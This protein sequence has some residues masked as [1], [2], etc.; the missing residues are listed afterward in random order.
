MTPLRIRLAVSML[1]CLCLGGCGARSTRVPVSG[2]VTLDGN[3]LAEAA[4]TF[5]PQAAGTLGVAV[6]DE[7]G[8][9]VLREAGIRP[10]IAPGEYEVA[11]YKADGPP[12]PA[13]ET[14]PASQI[15]DPTT[16]NTLAPQPSDQKPP[17]FIVP[18]RYGSPKTSELR[19]TVTGPIT[20][21][22]FALTIKPL[23]QP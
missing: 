11:I 21:L 2:V 5:M 7:G 19:A 15:A 17:K 14:T 10:G 3:P 8:R 13:V 12:L 6:T 9:F 1:A 20:D 18:E 23:K 22:V 16:F 4:V